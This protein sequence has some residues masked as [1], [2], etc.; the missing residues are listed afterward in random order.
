MNLCI[1]EGRLTRDPEMR[2]TPQQTAVVSFSIAINNTRYNRTAFPNVEAWANTAE[3]IAKF[4]HKGDL[5]RV[6]AELIQESWEDKTSGQKRQRDKYRI[7]RFEFPPT[8][9]ARNRNNNEEVEVSQD[10]NAEERH[11]NVRRAETSKVKPPNM[12]LIEE[13]EDDQDLPF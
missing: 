10:V 3:S 7:L 8:N 5:I 2:F 9:E 13:E 12:S 4:F 11:T 1:F 6:Y